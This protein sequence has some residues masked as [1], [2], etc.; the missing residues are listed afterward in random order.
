MRFELV[1]KSRHFSKQNGGSASRSLNMS[2]ESDREFKFPEN[3][4]W[5]AATSSHQ[6]EGNNTNNDWWHWEEEGRVQEKSGAACNQYLLYKE[7]FSLAKELGHN[8]HRFSLEWSRIEPEEGRFDNAVIRHYTGV[9]EELRRLGIEPVVTLHHFTLPLWLYKR[10]GWL[11]R[12]SYDIYARF[13]EKIVNELGHNV[14]YWITLNEPVGNIYNAYIEGSWPPGYRSFKDAMKVF[15]VLLK[16]HAFSYG[17]IHRIY[18]EKGWHRPE[19]SIAKIYLQFTPCR[20]S[21]FFDKLSTGLRHYYFNTLFVDALVKGYCIAPG[22]GIVRL[23]AK[24]TLD[25]LG[26][27]Y[28]TRDFVHY[29]GLTP[30]RIFG[31]IC[32]LKHH[33]DIAKRNLLSWEIYPQGIY[34]L[35]IEYSRYRL[36]ILITENGICTNDDRERIDFI[37]RHLKE[38]ARAIGEGVNV[39]GYIY[40]SLIDNFEWAHG[41]GPRFGLVE[42]DYK[43]QRRTARP[44]AHF[45]ADII[46]E[47]L[48]I[49]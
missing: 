19:V 18:K 27:N 24:N 3:F 43:T 10:G 17:N 5:G 7:D 12:H 31:D 20:N 39:M 49:A 13:V 38:A 42:V 21:S 26:I 28:Y 40:W 2:G 14:R 33:R 4:L 22:I 35:L 41:Y 45:F 16:A 46:K 25:F 29:A 34:E 30:R 37:S 32:S 36:P 15:G 44:S 9:I 11:A 6:V 23:P 47:G 8:A 48:P 1:A